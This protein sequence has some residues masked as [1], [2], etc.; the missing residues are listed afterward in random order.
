MNP[1]PTIETHTHTPHTHTHTHSHTF[2]LSLTHT[3]IHSHTHIHTIPYGIALA[4]TPV[5]MSYPCPC[6]I[7]EAG[8]FSLALMS[9]RE[10]GAGLHLFL[11]R[12][13]STC[14]RCTTTGASQQVGVMLS[15]EVTSQ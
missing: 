3:H 14:D 5:R 11:S 12:Q 7:P 8:Q 1:A 15:S 4:A 6:Y 10:R 2:S 13:M 9:G